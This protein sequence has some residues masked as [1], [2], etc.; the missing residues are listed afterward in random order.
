MVQ[1]NRS[2]V[3]EYTNGY[4]YVGFIWGELLWRK[5]KGITAVNLSLME[6]YRNSYTAL[7]MH[8]RQLE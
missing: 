1:D 5:E 7:Y 8:R 3:N 6:N 4:K 2:L